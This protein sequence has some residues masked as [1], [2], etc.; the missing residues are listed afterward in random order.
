RE[1]GFE[2]GIDPSFSILDEQRSL[3]LA[4]ESARETIRQQIRSGDEEVEQLFGDFGLAAL[5]DTL[6]SAGYW[7]NSLG[8]DSGWLEAR[9][10]DQR[11]AASEA[12]KQIDP[13]IREYGRNFEKAGEIADELDAR[14]AKHPL[15][16]RDDPQALLP[17]M[18]Q[19]AGVGP[20]GSLSR[21]V[22]IATER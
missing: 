7:L 22:S 17:R 14:K 3:D 4:R 9:V 11:R 15:R 12:E 1:H 19:I 8:A 6:V 10:A 18:G 13:G 2:T 20:A 5:V 21:L 16:K